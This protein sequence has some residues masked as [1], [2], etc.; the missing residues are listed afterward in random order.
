M[1]TRFKMGKV[2]LEAYKAMSALDKY[3]SESSIGKLQREMIK[4]RASQINGC[5]YCVNIHTKSARALA[6]GYYNGL[7][8]HIQRYKMDIPCQVI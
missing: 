4:I 5:A 2:Q 3:A 7:L 1:Q 8:D 6:A